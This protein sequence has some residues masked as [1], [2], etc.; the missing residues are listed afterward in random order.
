MFMDQIIANQTW[1]RPGMPDLMIGRERGGAI[2]ELPAS[3]PG[4]I[5]RSIDNAEGKSIMIFPCMAVILVSDITRPAPASIHTLE[6]RLR[7]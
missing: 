7:G 3:P 1:L 6:K 5:D 2:E 4:E